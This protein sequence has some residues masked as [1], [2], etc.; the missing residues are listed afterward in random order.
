MYMCEETTPTELNKT[1]HYA[2]SM[3]KKKLTNK[4]AIVLSH[5]MGKIN[6][7]C[8]YTIMAIP[9]V[10][11]RCCCYLKEDLQASWPPP[12]RELVL[13]QNKKSI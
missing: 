10:I 4:Y 5:W 9:A 1:T 3:N 7:L 8:Y 11:H 2:S 12:S 6:P 13:S